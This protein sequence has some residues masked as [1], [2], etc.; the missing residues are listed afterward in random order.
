MPVD[1]IRNKLEAINHYQQTAL[2]WNISHVENDFVDIYERAIA[3]YQ[4]IAA[5]TGVTMHPRGEHSAVLDG[6]MSGGKFDI[7]LFRGIS[8]TRSMKAARRELVVKHLRESLRDGEKAYIVLRNYLGGEYHLTADEVYEEGGR[9]VI[10]ESKN[11]TKAKLPSLEDIKDGLLKLI[12]YSNMDELLVNGVRVDFTTQL[13]LTGNVDGI[14]RLPASP[15]IIDAFMRRNR[16]SP[17][18]CAIIERLN[19]EARQNRNLNILITGNQ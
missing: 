7:E 11:S 16:F 13:K 9:L 2:H 18:Q 3:S 15:E 1:Y 19:Q 17:S 14:L 5:Q 4:R 8:L 6:Y 12:L 10:Q